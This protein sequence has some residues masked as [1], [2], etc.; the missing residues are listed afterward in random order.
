MANN[1]EYFTIFDNS[2]DKI[3]FSNR[4]KE[5]SKQFNESNYD[6]LEKKTDKK[7][8]MNIFKNMGYGFKYYPGGDFN[9]V[10]QINSFSFQLL[11]IVKRGFITNYLNVFIDD[12]K[13]N[14]QYNFGFIY[15]SLV[16]DMNAIITT[17]KF[18]DYAE[19]E[20]IAK[21]IISIYE[22][23]KIEF[24]RQVDEIEQ[25]PQQTA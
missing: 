7:K 25:N 22:D 8:I 23:F 6:K 19:F 5:L 9:L 20:E 1:R 24:L 2:L 14:K 21:N 15:R 10:E 4:Y 3:N 13:I 16:G 17:P 18:I 11:F 12:K